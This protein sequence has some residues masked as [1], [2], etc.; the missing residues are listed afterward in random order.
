M[1]PYPSGDL[2]IGHWYIVTPTR[3]A[4]PVPADARLQRVLPDRLRCVRAAGRERRHQ[5]RRASVHLDDAEH[6]DDAPPVPDD[7]RDVRLVDTR[8]SPPTPPTTA[9]TSGCSCASSRPGWPIGRCRR[10]TGAPTTARWRASRSR[11]PIGVAGAAARW[12]RSATSSSGSC[13]RPPTPTSC[14]TSSGIDWPDPIRIQ[15]TNWIGRS[16]GAEI[17]F[18]IAPT[19]T[20]PAATMLR[21]FTTRPDT[22]FGATFMVLAPEHPLVAELTAPGPAGRGR[23]VRRPGPPADRDRAPVDRPREDRR[24]HRRR[25]R[26]TRS[27]AS[28]SRSSS[29][30]TCWPATARARSWP[31]PPT[32]SATS[33]SRSGSGCRSG[34]SSPRPASDA[35]APMDRRFIAHAADERLVN[36]GRST[37]CAADEGGTA[38]VAWL[39]ET[40]RGRAEGHLPP[41]RLAGQPPALLGHADPGHLLRDRRH[42]AGAG[43]GPAGPAAGDRR[44]PRQRRQPAQPRRGVPASRPARAAAARRGARPTRWTRSSTRRGTGSA[45]CR[46]TRAT[47]RSTPSWSSA[48]RRSTSTRAAPSTRSCTCC[49]PLLHQGDGRSSA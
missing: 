32:T 11:V 41:A 33:C 12:S 3:R 42:R 27:T 10:S 2:H 7:G 18:E 48:G 43:R 24:P 31:C 37:A 21:V 4:R 38:I 17:D 14:S 8:S 20:S 45:T 6:R 22:L 1:Y 30:T 19:T 29:P 25:R 34:A 39:A 5:E 28:G 40:G 16:E 36:S 23:R 47:A 13:A 49:T 26:S 9:G 44:L 15:Q 46:P 35:D